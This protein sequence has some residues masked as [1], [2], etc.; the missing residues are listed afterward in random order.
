MRC[1]HLRRMGWLVALLL[2]GGDVMGHEPPDLGPSV[3]LDGMKEL[4]AS[5]GISWPAM[6]A[7]EWLWDADPEAEQPLFSI[8]LNHM[9]PFAATVSDV[10]GDG[11]PDIAYGGTYANSGVVSSATGQLLVPIVVP[12]FA[13]GYD[14][15]G[16]FDGDGVRD[17]LVSG[18]TQDGGV[19]LT[20]AISNTV[21]A[22]VL[23]NPA[24]EFGRAAKAIPD[25][26]GDGLDD[27]LTGNAYEHGGWLG[28][29]NATE[30]SLIYRLD[31]GGQTDRFGLHIAT[32]EDIDG[33]GRGDFAVMTPSSQFIAGAETYGYELSVRSGRRGE[34]LWSRFVPGSTDEVYAMPFRQVGDLNGDGAPD[35]ALGLSH[36]AE[37]RIYSCRT[38]NELFRLS[39]VAESSFGYAVAGGADFD[40][41][42][43]DDLLVG[44]STHG[45][46]DGESL[47]P[48]A[49][50]LF[51]GRRSPDFEPAATPSL[52]SL[53]Q[54][55]SLSP[56]FGRRV[57]VFDDIDGDGREEIG[58]VSGS[59]VYAFHGL[60]IDVTTK[61]G[62]TSP[63]GL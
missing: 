30:E 29:Y 61:L 47:E 48:G 7:N 26:D 21:P 17:L 45:I 20:F 62:L 4:V 41:D 2:S 63:D 16:D 35:L 46:S 3:V 55:Q 27:I 44:A 12:N 39:S 59:H 54:I 25:I 50:F 23:E 19:V 6:P 22:I 18:S 57:E 5:T 32:F 38:G 49:V 43:L 58:V 52:E 8:E 36:N 40:G 37:V 51:A 9:I 28:V 11:Y 14:N 1:I 34:V 42:G 31:S 10:D 13:P 15:R 24:Y 60:V 33:D 56:A 53:L